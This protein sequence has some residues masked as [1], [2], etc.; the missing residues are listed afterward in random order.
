VT[1]RSD[2]PREHPA[3]EAASGDV[4]KVL[5]DDV[6]AELR[7]HEKPPTFYGPRGRGY[8]PDVYVEGISPLSDVQSPLTIGQMDGENPPKG[9]IIIDVDGRNAV[10]DTYHSFHREFS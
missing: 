4:C 8:I 9:R 2:P 6:T 7:G 10:L 5:G 3:P 1:D